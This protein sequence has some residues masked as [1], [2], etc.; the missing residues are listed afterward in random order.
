[1]KKLEKELKRTIA[2]TFQQEVRDAKKQKLE[3]AYEV[4]KARVEATLVA[5]E[6]THL[7]RKMDTLWGCK[8]KSTEWMKH[9]ERQR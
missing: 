6:A 9:E 5:K 4:D 1:M 7:Q 2:S 8:Q 3:M